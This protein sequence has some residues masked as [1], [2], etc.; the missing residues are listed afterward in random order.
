MFENI[1]IGQY[2]PGDSW[3]HKLDPRIK[4]L[5]LVVMIV[6]TFLIPI[7][8]NFEGNNLYPALALICLLLINVVCVVSAKIPIKKVLR[9]LKG[10]IFLLVFTTIIQIFSTNT[11]YLLLESEMFLSLTSVIAMVVLIIL[12]N[13]SKKFTKFKTTYFLLM[14]VSLFVVQAFL[15]YISFAKYE[16]KIYSEGV[17]RSAFLF[18]RIINVVV[19]SSILTFTTMTTDLN[20]GIESLLKPLKVIKLPVDTFAML[21]TL[22]L[23]FIPTLLQETD[24]IMKAQASRGV[25]FKESKLREKIVQIVS[26][27]IP[28]LVV[29]IKKAEELADA[30]DVKGY[31]ISAKRTRIDYF[32]LGTKDFLSFSVS[33]MLLT[34]IILMKVFLL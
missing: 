32:V 28:I 14:V 30:M 16:L 8:L 22:T 17:F 20:F 23:R 24:K 11:G 6:A 12:Y 19:V 7:P 27:L 26:L 4:I 15:P 29:S 18:L 10:L 2:I 25:D 13:W 34:T 21:L 9:G 31:V 5:M 1:T 33:L 3:L